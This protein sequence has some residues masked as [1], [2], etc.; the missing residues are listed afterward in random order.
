[1]SKF[2]HWTL[3]MPVVLAPGA[4]ASLETILK[5]SFAGL[6]GGSAKYWVTY[7]AASELAAWNFDY[8]NPAKPAV[9]EWHVGGKA[10]GGGFENQAFVDLKAKTAA[11]FEAGNAIGPLAYVTLENSLVPGSGN[12][13]IQ[14]SAITVDPRL[15]SPVAGKG[16]PKPGDLVATAYKFAD[17]YDLPVNDNDCHFIAAAVAAATGATLTD[18]TQSLTPSENEEGGFWRIAYRGSDAHPVKDWQAL[19]R[20]GDIVRMGWTGGGQHT[21]L[22]LEAQKDGTIK[23]YD[24]TLWV[25]GQSR[26]GVHA[27][28]FDDLTIPETVT[29]YRLT[30]DKLYLEK[31]TGGD[32]KI[33][34][35]LFADRLVGLG[36]NDVMNGGGNS[37]RLEGGKGNDTLT[38]GSG[39]DTF[40]FDAALNARGNVDGI[41]DFRNRDDTIALDQRIFTMLDKTGDARPLD[42]ECFKDVGLEGAR[43]ERDD[44]ILYDSRTGDLSY[45]KDGSG[46]AAA[47]LFAH[48][49]NPA[50]AMLKVSDFLVI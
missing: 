4:E 9:S 19:V 24:N 7:S 31:G 49:D 26:I 11:V 27:V 21:A 29:I 38:G 15:M 40:V 45:D 6:P 12:S 1:M 14:Y 10:I 18:A 39:A 37:D 48:L 13:F 17:F 30:T 16:A 36:G 42:A 46:K 22:V 50:A 3:P 32:E 28:D 8:W 25:G 5:A 33:A 23:V 44:R 20:P 2:L 35:T 43:L 34:G 41:T 47:V